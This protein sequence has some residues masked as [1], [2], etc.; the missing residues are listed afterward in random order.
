MSKKD[1]FWT[2]FGCVAWAAAIALAVLVG[3]GILDFKMVLEF[4]CYVIIGLAIIALL[5]ISILLV[6][7]S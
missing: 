4:F 5:L 7:H 1:K 3:L 6:L 2:A